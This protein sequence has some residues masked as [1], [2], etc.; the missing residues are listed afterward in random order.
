MEPVV[1]TYSGQVYKLLCEDGHYYIGSTITE[2]K[3]RLYH[4]K[5]HSLLYP[6]RKVYNHILTCGWD[7]VNIGCV[8][9]VKSNSKNALRKRENEYIKESLSD[10]LCL[11]INRAHLTKRELLQQ[12]QE[13]IDAN[14][15]KVDAYHAN[16]RKENAEERA[17]YSRQYTAEH[18]EE[19]QATK[20]EY[21]EANKTEILEKQ[22]MYVE[23]HVEQIKERKKQ[24]AAENKETINET[25]K[26]YAE[27][28]KEAIQQRGKEYYETNKEAIKEKLKVYREANAETAKEYGKAYRAKKREELVETHL[29]ECGGKYSWTHEA[30]H[31]ESKRHMEHSLNNPL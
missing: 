21:Y 2:L 10:P 9:I 19:V 6:D 8:E 1:S 7:T 31:K 26:R 17:E 13:Y 20:R 30:R 14:K 3:Y 16:Y 24:W 18:P 5:K 27:E 28:N 11:N 23:A 15:D 29:C 22:K 12:Q 25:R 4:H